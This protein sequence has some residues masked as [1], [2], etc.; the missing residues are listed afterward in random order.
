MAAAAAVRTLRLLLAAMLLH[1][2]ASAQEGWRVDGAVSIATRHACALDGGKVMCWG[3][4]S[5]WWNIQSKVE[6]DLEQTTVAICSGG[7]DY[8]CALSAQGQVKCWGDSGNSAGLGYGDIASR[9]PPYSGDGSPRLPAVDLGT[10]RT[11]RQISCDNYH[12]CAL[13]DTNQV[14]CW[15]EEFPDGEVSSRAVRGDEPG[16]M[17]DALPTLDL[18][19]GRSAVSV[20][21]GPSKT[22][23]I[24]DNN[25]VKCWG[26]YIES[27]VTTVSL[28]TNGLVPLSLTLP[29]AGGYLLVLLNDGSVIRHWHNHYEE[30]VTYVYNP[31]C[32]QELA[33][34]ITSSHSHGCILLSNGVVK[35]WSSGHGSEYGQLGTGN[36]EPVSDF[37]SATPVNLGSGKSAVS[38][39][40]SEEA[41]CAI[42][43]TGE[44]KCWGGTFR[45]SDGAQEVNGLLGVPGY[46]N[47]GDDPGEMGDNLQ[48]ATTILSRAPCGA[49]LTCPAGLPPR[50]MS[51]VC[52]N[53]LVTTCTGG[54]Y[55]ST[56]NN[57]NNS[58]CLKGKIT[59]SGGLC[60]GTKV[61][62]SACLP[63][64]TDDM[65]DAML[66][67]LGRSMGMT[68]NMTCD[69][70]QTMMDSSCAIFGAT[71]KDLCTD[72]GD[73]CKALLAFEMCKSDDDCKTGDTA[74]LVP[75]CSVITKRIDV[76]CKDIDSMNLMAYVSF[77][78]RAVLR[79]GSAPPSMRPAACGAAKC[80]CHRVLAASSLVP[81]PSH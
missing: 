16:E 18:G 32:T 33:V 31:G 26:L 68:F 9:D 44:V 51:L 38:I 37:A 75:C 81:C 5:P 8:T 63:D 45:N 29:T 64:M 19:A 78:C 66:T 13:L 48:A 69:A 2:A 61:D 1:M 20:A 71:A 54:V 22:C 6:I 43:D 25:Q 4:P 35:C 39:T 14:K 56:T 58:K 47:L 30:C 76:V 80:S 74:G 73:A 40:S 50:P 15:G 46:D 62:Y 36:T 72:R 21:C 55:E 23:V 3:D 67:E 65:K 27:G 70:M 57:N 60:D 24:L 34:S 53:E 7:N 77:S 17:G 79:R 12:R 10:G 49:D 11:A 42:L 28:P 52:S 41:N 59:V